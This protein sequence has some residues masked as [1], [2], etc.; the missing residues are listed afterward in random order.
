MDE[1][2]GLIH[3]YFGY[4]KGKT[5]AA[6]GLA[7]RSVGYGKKVVI[8]Q[9]LKNT[10]SGEILHF[11]E[12]G[13]VTVLR[14]TAASRFYEDMTEEEKTETARIQEQNL[15]KA[16]SLANGGN[17]DMLVL[18]EV[19]DAYQMGLLNASMFEDFVRNKPSGLE[20]VITG[21]KREHWLIEEA[22]YVTEMVK[23]KH[24]YE[25]GIKARKGIEF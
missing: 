21:H 3:F 25:K 9:F 24:P 7:L 17:C 14:G 15:E 22:D 5:T 11:S 12:L 8:V 6:M 10:Q 19:V 2:K 23:L 1:T 13:N 20:L 4:G 16:I 18:D